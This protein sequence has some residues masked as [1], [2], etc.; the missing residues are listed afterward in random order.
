MDDSL[1]AG[2]QYMRLHSKQ[3]ALHG[4]GK[5]GDSAD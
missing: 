5:P 1:I 2:N 3:M 4:V